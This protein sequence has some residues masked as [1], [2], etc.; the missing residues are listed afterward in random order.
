MWESEQ[1]GEVF[2][3]GNYHCHHNLRMA[4][5]A[6]HHFDSLAEHLLVSPVQYLM[7]LHG[8]SDVRD[9]KGNLIDPTPFSFE[10]STSYAGVPL[11]LPGNYSE[12][13][14][15]AHLGKFGL[16]G[17]YAL[18]PIES[19]SGGQKARLCLA[20]VMIHKPHVL[21]LDEPTNHFSIDAIDAL[22]IALRD[23]VGAVIVVSHNQSLLCNVCNQLGVIQSEKLK[24]LS[25][26]VSSADKPPSPPQGNQRKQ[27]EK[28]KDSQVSGSVSTG[29]PTFADLLEGYLQSVLK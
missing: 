9:T 17:D 4:M 22:T 2:V 25:S 15:R 6:Q 3:E 24:V 23:F 27:S 29:I 10:N 1:P 18:Q 13:D 14:A 8:A 21:L 28:N 11:T 12:L 19:L 7:L 20:A 5:L 26:V 16:C